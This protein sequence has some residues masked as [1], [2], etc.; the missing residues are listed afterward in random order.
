[1]ELMIAVD[2]TNPQHLVASWMDSGPVILTTHARS[3]DGGVTW[4]TAGNF[5]PGVNPAVYN[6]DPTVTIDGLGNVFVSLANADA[7][8]GIYVLR[9]ADGGLTFNGS[10]AIEPATWIDKPWITSDP[11]SNYVYVAYDYGID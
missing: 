8:P 5:A 9:P 11:V 7:G 10:V 4:Q 3:L 1:G 2:P 6:Y